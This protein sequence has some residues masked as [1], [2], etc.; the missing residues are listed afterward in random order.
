M[1]MNEDSNPVTVLKRF[2]DS[3][4]EYPSLECGWASGCVF[5]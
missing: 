4:L 3:S 2:S 1:E 5:M